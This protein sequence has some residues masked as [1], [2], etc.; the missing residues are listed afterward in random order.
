MKKEERYEELSDINEDYVKDAQASKTKAFRPVWGIMAACAAFLIFWGV[1]FV[2]KEA[3][4]DNLS[5]LPMLT[6]AEHT[7]DGMGFEG[8]WAYDVSELKNANPW[9]EDAE[10]STLPVYKNQLEHDENYL[11]TEVD[12]DAMEERL[13]EVSERLGMDASERHFERETWRQWWIVQADEMKIEVDA[14][15]T[16]TVTFEPAIQLP[17]EYNFNYYAS[18]EDVA[19]IAGYLK[20][21]YKDFI[22]MEN[23]KTD[24]YGGDYNIYFQQN[25]LFAF[26]DGSGDITNQILNYNFNRVTFSYDEE[27]KLSRLSFFHPDLSEKTGDYPIISADEA[28]TL[29]ANGN[30]I[31]TVPYEMPGLDYVKKVELIYRTGYLEEYFMPYY[32]FYVEI[33]DEEWEEGLKTYGAY[34]VPAVEGSYITNMPLWDGNFQ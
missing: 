10:L 7:S 18:Y 31:T 32:R 23:P 26:Y 21:T 16:A 27:G 14:D 13:L 17:K 33:P 2:W 5:E 22:G 25:Y 29:L 24:I 6:I 4:G 8:Y 28:K 9:S 15:M 20:E 12:S 34:Y 30:Y 11:I 19:P 3:P 1:R